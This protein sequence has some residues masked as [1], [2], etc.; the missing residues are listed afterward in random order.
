WFGWAVDSPSPGASTPSNSVPDLGKYLEELL[1]TKQ[2]TEETCGRVKSAIASLAASK[3]WDV[4]TDPNGGLSIKL[5]NGEIYVINKDCSKVVAEM[6]IGKLSPSTK[7]ALTSVPRGMIMPTDYK[8]Q[9]DVSL[10]RTIFQILMYAAAI[11]WAVRAFQ[12]LLAGELTEMFITLFIGL[13]VVA[14]M[15]ALY[16]WM[17]A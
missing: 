17:P 6:P 1:N 9:V 14:S 13:I 11:F 8:F 12:K 2:K 10:F 15:Y 3:N 5:P 7:E 4:K 16:R